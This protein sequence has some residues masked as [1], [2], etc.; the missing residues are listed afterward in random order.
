MH[1]FYPN[2]LSI[3][4]SVIGKPL[5][6]D[7]PTADRTR[8]AYTR[9][10]VEINPKSELKTTIPMVFEDGR[11]CIVDVEYV[12]KPLQCSTCS[13]FFHNEKMCSKR[14]PPPL[15]KQTFVQK[16]KAMVTTD[17]GSSQPIDQAMHNCTGIK[18][19]W[20][21]VS[22][23]RKARNPNFEEVAMVPSQGIQITPKYPPG[24]EPITPKLQVAINEHPSTMQN[25]FSPL[26][27]IATDGSRVDE[28]LEG[29]GDQA[30]NESEIGKGDDNI[31]GINGGGSVLQGS[32]ASS[33]HIGVRSTELEKGGRVN[34]PPPDLL[35]YL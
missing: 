9:V 17:V 29:I 34:N 13:T 16:T 12:W 21:P 18:E 7:G 24:F 3:I 27:G 20:T 15:L 30:M 10:C 33:Q 1:A 19:N 2:G 5:L 22:H 31:N 14:F 8:M 11:R 28:G 32:K 25:T 26:M 6:L 35:Y 23:K 4:S